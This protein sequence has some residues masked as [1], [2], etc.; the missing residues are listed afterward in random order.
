M[1]ALWGVPAAARNRRL[2]L[3]PMTSGLVDHALEL[4]CG[5]GAAR[6]RRMFGGHGLYVDDL[7]IALI[8]GERLYYK[9]D[10]QT[11]PRFQAAGSE[12]F[13]YGRQG[14]E[15]VTLGYW[16]VPP[17]AMESPALMLPWAR[18]ALEAALRARNAKP[19]AR[20]GRAGSVP[21]TAAP[22]P[23]RKKAQAR[24]GSRAAHADTAE[25]PAVRPRRAAQ[26]ANRPSKPSGRRGG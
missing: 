22:R 5:L 24:S 18:L 4:L 20:P 10:A 23:T 15:Q 6:A 12:P 2:T 1:G 19:A 21:G 9:T 26:A 25:P 16:T 3:P 7:F 14:R 8:A 11:R 17:E 13:V